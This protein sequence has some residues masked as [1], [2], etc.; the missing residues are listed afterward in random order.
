MWIAGDHIIV[1]FVAV[2]ARRHVDANDVGEIQA[3]YV[4][5][6][7][8]RSGAGTLLLNKAESVLVEMGYVE[9]SLWVFE[10]NEGARRFYEAV[11]W[12]PEE[13]TEI[14]NLA[15]VDVTEI[16]YRKALM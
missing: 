7:R 2:S 3:L 4:A 12:S 1:G 10:A 13:R 14:L 15:G 8:W 9:A 5:P 6:D 11:G 16:R